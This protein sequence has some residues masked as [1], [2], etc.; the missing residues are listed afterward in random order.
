MIKSLLCGKQK[1]F[2]ENFIE[3]AQAAGGDRKVSQDMT[4]GG[5]CILSRILHKLYK[6]FSSAD[7]NEKAARSVATIASII[8]L[9]METELELFGLV[10]DSE[11]AVLTSTM[12]ILTSIFKRNHPEAEAYY[13]SGLNAYKV[14]LSNYGKSENVKTYFNDIHTMTIKYIETRDDRYIESSRSLVIK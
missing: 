11:Q 14:V 10:I 4:Y 9:S 8:I 2:K 6:G 3:A 12:M 1:S 7:F 13:K 5:M